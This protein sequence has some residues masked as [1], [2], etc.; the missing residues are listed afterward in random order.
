MMSDLW[1]LSVM[2]KRGDDL[3][4][5]AGLKRAGSAEEAEKLFIEEIE[6]DGREVISIVS[7]KPKVVW[8]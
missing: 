2:T 7:S 5:F 3:G 6:V 8:V 4:H 1:L